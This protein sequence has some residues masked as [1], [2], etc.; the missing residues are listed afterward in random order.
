MA[1]RELPQKLAYIEGCGYELK[2]PVVLKTDTE[3]KGVQFKA[4]EQTTPPN[5]GKRNGRNEI[6][7]GILRSIDRLQKKRFTS[8]DVWAEYVRA[9][10]PQTTRDTVFVTV[11][12]IGRNG[13]IQRCNPPRMIGNSLVYEKQ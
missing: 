8:G 10:E 3:Y 7:D 6:L 12:R 2:S 9:K 4:T 11:S 5:D 13:L 1:H